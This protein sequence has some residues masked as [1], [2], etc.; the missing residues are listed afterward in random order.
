[1]HSVFSLNL[2]FV[3]LCPH[4]CNLLD[5]LVHS[6]YSLKLNCVD[7]YPHQ[8]NLLDTR[9]HSEYSLKLNCVD[10]CP[11]QCNLLDT[12]VYSVYSLKKAK[13]V[14]PTDTSWRPSSPSTYPPP[15]QAHQSKLEPFSHLHI[16]S[17]YI[18]GLVLLMVPL[19]ENP[20]RVIW[21]GETK[22]RII[23]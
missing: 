18:V 14:P 17:V 4:Q 15:P 13:R 16:G 8:C 2:N 6:V 5:T 12:R 23:H 3:D 20:G 19:E 1:M 9:V 22:V 7:L 10:L 11:H 21:V